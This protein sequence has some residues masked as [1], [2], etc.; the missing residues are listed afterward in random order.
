MFSLKK[1]VPSIWHVNLREANKPVVATNDGNY[2]NIR[3]RDDSIVTNFLFINLTPSND[4]SYTVGSLSLA[5]S[6]KALGYDCDFYDN[7][8][9]SNVQLDSAELRQSPKETWA[10]YSTC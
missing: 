9:H 7:I 10:T 8:I 3:T 1:D 6:L 2:F 5:T 4:D